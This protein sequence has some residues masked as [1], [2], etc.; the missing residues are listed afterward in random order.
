MASR[1]AQVITRFAAK[2]E[3]S[4]I[5]EQQGPAVLAKAGRF[6]SAILTI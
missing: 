1:L 6:G 2:D 4:L 3:M 5:L